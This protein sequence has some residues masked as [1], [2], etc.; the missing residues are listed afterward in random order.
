MN[1]KVIIPIIVCMSLIVIGLVTYFIVDMQK[2]KK[3]DAV[4]LNL[5]EDLTVEFGSKANISDF[6]EELQGSLISD[7]NVD[8]SKLGNNTVTFEYKSIRNKKKVKSFEINVVDRTKPK[9]YMGGS[10]TVNKGYSGDITDL[11]FSGDNCD[12]TPIRKVEGSYDLNTV[13]KL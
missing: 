1:K 9:I 4:A 5:K 8:T 12:S 7:S 2:E 13:R 3:E 6:I 10:V 11:I